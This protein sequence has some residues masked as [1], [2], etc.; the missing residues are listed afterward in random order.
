[1]LDMYGYEQSQT[2]FVALI[3]GAYFGLINS[4]IGWGV[5]QDRYSQLKKK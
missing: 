4:L 1:M 5:S 3:I 2:M